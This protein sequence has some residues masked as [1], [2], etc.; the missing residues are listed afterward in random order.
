MAARLGQGKLAPEIVL[1]NRAQRRMITS[2]P[3]RSTYCSRL[4]HRSS[5]LGLSMPRRAATCWPGPVTRPRAY[6]RGRSPW[7]KV[8]PAA[9]QLCCEPSPIRR[10]CQNRLLTSTKYTRV[11]P[12]RRWTIRRRRNTPGR[13]GRRAFQVE[14]VPVEHHLPVGKDLQRQGANIGAPC[15]ARLAAN[16]SK[17]V[18]VALEQAM[19]NRLPGV[20]KN[21]EV[22]SEK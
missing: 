1:L 13:S 2:P 22:P 16:Y 3:V 9:D 6:A 18:A 10:C 8:A 11:C 21:S 14:G 17:R 12:G 5:G 7:T 4:A 15:S 20:S 19:N